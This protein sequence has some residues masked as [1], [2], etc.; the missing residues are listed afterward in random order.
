MNRKLPLPVIELIGLVHTLEQL[1]ENIGLIKNE[2]TDDPRLTEYQAKRD[3]II[4]LI[5][6]KIKD[7]NL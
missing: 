5:C 4:D 6:R 3:S 7:N 2:V 1:E